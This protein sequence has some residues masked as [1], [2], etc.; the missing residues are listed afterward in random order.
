[1]EPPRVGQANSPFTFTPNTKIT[2]QAAFNTNYP[3]DESV[4]RTDYVVFVRI[5]GDLPDAVFCWTKNETI[6]RFSYD[7]KNQRFKPLPGSAIEIVGTVTADV[8][9]TRLIVQAPSSTDFVN[10]PVRLSIGTV[11]SGTTLPLIP[12]TEESFFTIPTSGTVQVALDTGTLNWNPADLLT[13]DAQTVRFQRQTF[14][15]YKKSTGNIGLID[16]ALLLNPIPKADQ[17]PLVRIGFY[18]WLLPIAKA[19]DGALSPDPT[20][21]TVEWS[22]TTGLVKFN[23]GDVGTYTGRAVYYDGV[24]LKFDLQL[25][26]YLFGTVLS[27]GNFSPLPSDLADTFFLIPGVVQFAETHIVDDLSLLGEQGVVEIRRSD[28]LIKFSLADEAA[29][30]SYSVQ[31]YVPDYSIERGMILRMRRTPVDPEAIDPDLKDVSAVYESNDSSLAD[32]IVGFPKVFLPAVPSESF[33]ITVRVEQGTGSFTGTL[34]RLDIP[35]PPAGLGYVVDL[36]KQELYYARRKNNVLFPQS[37]SKPYG[38]VQLSDPMVYTA[39]LVLELETSPG[40]GIY[41]TLAINEDVTFDSN[42]GLVTLV[43]TVGEVTVSSSAG[44]FSGTTFTD[45]SQDFGVAGVIPGDLLVVLSGDSKGVYTIV[46]VGSSTVTTDLPGT[47]ESHLLYEIRHG[48]EILADRYFKE[49]PPLDPNTSVQRIVS[50]GVATNSPR[51][52]IPVDKIEVSGF[53]KGKT[54]TMTLTTVVDDAS[55]TAPGSLPS[56]SIEVALD[57]GNLNFSSSDLGATIY[58]AKT[59]KIGTEFKIQPKLGFVQFTDRLL[60]SEE[61]FVRYAILDDDDNKVLVEERGTFLV[62]KEL[63]SHPTPTSTVS[64]NPLGRELASFPEAKAFR[65]GRPQTTGQQVSFNYSNS[66]VTFLPDNQKQTIFPHGQTVDPSER[67]YVDYYIYEAFGGEDSLTVGRPP[68]LGVAISIEDSTSSFQ[69]AGDRTTEFPLNHLLRVDR[70]EAYLLAAPAYDSGTDTTT[71]NLV[72]PQVFRSD[73]QNPGLAVTSGPTRTEPLFALPAYFVTEMHA[74]ETVA[75]GSK[76]MKLVGDLSQTYAHGVVVHWTNGSDVLDFNIV[77]GSTYDATSDRTTVTFT[78]GGARQYASTSVTLKRSSNPILPTPV[79]KAATNLS[80][81]LTLP[82]V[83]FRR[84]EGQ[85]GVVLSQ[86]DGYS[87]DQGGQVTFTAPLQDNEQLVIGYTGAQ[88]I[89]DG[90]GFRASYSHSVVPSDANG[91]DGQ[92]LLMDYTTFSPDTFYWRVEKISTIR[93]ELRQKYQSDAQSSIPSGGP[94]LSNSSGSKLAEQGRESLFFQEGH[95]ANEDVVARATLKFFNDGINYLED[96]LQSMDGRIVGDHDGRFLFDGNIDNPV[97]TSVSS[98]TNQIDDLLKVSDAP[99]EVTFPPFA[100]TFIGTYKKM[101][102]PSKFSR[103][104]PTQRYLYSAAKDPAGLETGDTILDLGFQKLAAVN[105]VT[106]RQ[107]WAIVTQPA[108]AGDTVL[109][110]DTTS[111]LEDLLRPAFKTSTY[112]HRV[113]IVRQDGTALVSVKDVVNQTPTTLTLGSSLAVAIPVGATVYQVVYD[114]VPPPVPFPKF[115]R[116]GFDFGVKLDDGVLTH[117]QAFPPFDGSI[118]GF[119]PELEIQNPA[120]EEILDV[121]V[122][123][124]NSITEPY[125]VPALDGSTHDDDNNRTLPIRTPTTNSEGGLGVGYIYVEK[126]AIDSPSGTLRA[127]TTPPFVGIGNLNV[128]AKIITHSGGPFPSPIPKVYDL[129]EIRSGMNANSGFYQ[130]VAVAGATITVATAFPFFDTG[131][132]FTVTTSSTLHTGIGGTFTTTTLTDLSANFQTAGVKAGHTV[133]VRTGAYA[134]FRR[135]VTAV[136][137]ATQLTITALP[138]GT[139]ASYRVDNALGTYGGSGSILNNDLV[140]ALQGEIQRLD[141]ASSSEQQGIENFFNQFFTTI[142]THTTGETFATT[143]LHDASGNF[144]AAGVEAKQF[145]Y[146]RSGSVAGI[147]KIDSVTSATDLDIT[148]SFPGTASG[149]TYKVVS[150]QGLNLKALQ[151]TFGVL[152]NVDQAISDTNA[153]YSIVNTPVPVIEDASAFGR[154][155]LT[156]DLD[157]RLTVV[158]AR[159]ANLEDTA[160]GDPIVLSSVLSSSGK[161]YNKRYVWI[162]ARINLEKGILS[163][164]ERAESDREKAVKDIL[165]QLTK[166]L[167]T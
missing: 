99:V 84:I 100:I 96:A 109:H 136:N 95:L 120:G 167:T 25:S 102:Q 134:G 83:V 163:K 46:A 113:T 155:T 94:R 116:L 151:D 110:V 24:A 137:S 11:G 57:T 157:S 27:P 73:F 61:V 13:F 4:P 77:E 40:S 107:P 144:L 62:R 111:G 6:N 29:Y 52:S 53:R 87:I 14:F 86:P 124:F 17:F 143:Q 131:F 139:V 162:D 98:V 64:F 9:T 101:Y 70:T 44:S 92:I 43:N 49:I 125:R 3:T 18:D 80:P 35:S 114:L 112:D 115:Y 36:E 5:D 154:R 32:P 104:Y 10:F 130:I 20:S 129:V 140:P 88:V 31:A 12:V 148:E 108:V 126:L 75:R 76:T 145:V 161:L 28:G 1:M 149:I 22:Q 69:I 153:F 121:N 7:G 90:R 97:R 93:S 164:K 127:V 42:S 41:N 58:W 48:H 63:A 54:T 55:F 105:Q 166:L 47:T 82:Y 71:V 34:P 37:A 103:F 152:L 78:A 26:P 81:D 123:L 117:I 65:G 135:Q 159:I 160:S 141:T 50:L 119:P 91:L 150:A 133:V 39:E 138:A 147:Y 74:Y 165:K 118:P 16:D 23:S 30:G 66:S 19:N 122:D 128:T 79:A 146:I 51:L 60:Q 158:N 67:I 59:L 21:G 72:S 56:G 15:S 68:M 33:P 45:T 2:N 156:S 89:S 38:T 85:V 132:T 142:A 106:R 8:N